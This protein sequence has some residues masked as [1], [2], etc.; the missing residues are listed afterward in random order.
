[1]TSP[2]PPAVQIRGLTKAYPAPRGL[3]DLLRPWRPGPQIAA[4][5]D[6]TLEAS[7]GELVAILGPNGAGK[8]TLLKIL[9][10]LVHPTAGEVIVHGADLAQQPEAGR[11]RVGYVLTEERSFFWR[12]SVQDNLRFFGALEG[13]SGARGQQRVQWVARLLA[14][15]DLLTRRFSDL[16]AGQRQRV[17]LARGMLADPPVLV[18]DEATR[19]LDPG[20]AEQVRRMVRELIVQRQGRAVLFATHDLHEA[21]AIADRV[22][23]LV[24]GKVACQGRFEDVEQQ[25]TEAFRAE[26]HAEESAL[27]GVLGETE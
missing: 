1:V 24:G 17:A 18:F 7:A 11:Q 20:R 8:T 22:V 5:S 13:Y 10:G 16:S 23:L 2:G 6:V 21:R 3:K 4:L 25:V 12:L 26:A 27:A 19:A 14:L 9:A 15:Q